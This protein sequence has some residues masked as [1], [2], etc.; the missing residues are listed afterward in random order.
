MKKF[1]AGL[2]AILLV[3]SLAAPVAEAKQKNDFKHE[4]K[5]WFKDVGKDF[6]ARF[7]I[8]K[9]FAKRIIVGYPGGWFKPGNPV[10]H[11]EAIIMALRIMGWEDEIDWGKEVPKN[12]ENRFKVWDQGY[13][14]IAKAVEKGIVKPEELWNFKPNEPAK[15]Y[16]VARYIVRAIG[17]EEEALKHMNEKLPFKDAKA[18]PKDA[19]GYVYVM[20]EMGLMKG[21]PNN[22]FQPNAP[23]NRAEMAKII[24]QLDE[25]QGEDKE[26]LC[27]VVSVDEENMSI[28]VKENGKVN[29][30]KLEEGVPVYIDKNYSDIDQITPGDEVKL[31]FNDEGKVVF[32]QVVG[33]EVTTK[34]KGIVVYVN[35][36]K[37]TVTLFTYSGQEKGYV[38]ILEEGDIEGR[39]FELETEYD[40]FVLVGD[41]DGLDDYVGKKIVVMGEVKNDASIYMRGLLLEVDKWFEVTEKNTL[42]FNVTSETW[43]EMDGKQIRL[44][45]LKEGA[46]VELTARKDSAISIKVI[47][48]VGNK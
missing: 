46:Y 37:Q 18:I 10:S 40:R 26:T 29:T 28:T 32:I 34:A 30:Y 33:K 19:V 13:Y 38:G 21:Y 39:H 11:L 20:V 12:L 16:E 45:D 36:E 17:K 15:R 35:E 31:I 6:W 4:V 5:S 2:L 22:T 1:I 44:A 43:I 3:I 24:C 9:M 47:E 27:V 8:E 48:K 42:T 25:L 41:T 23:I 7:F 14:Y